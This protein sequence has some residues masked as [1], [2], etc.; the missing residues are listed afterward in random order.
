YGTSAFYCPWCDGYE[1]RGKRI[2]ILADED[3]TSNLVMLIANWS[4]DLIICTDGKSL[5][6]DEDKQML[7]D[8]GF[9]YNE[10]PISRMTG[11]D[12][13]LKSIEFEDGTTEAVEGMFVKMNWDTNFEFLETLE[14]DREDD[15]GLRTN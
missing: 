5:L 2:A 1:L 13:K 12:G 15:G 7:E 4:K 14:P 3:S 11:N 6:K 9:E 10:A 8:K